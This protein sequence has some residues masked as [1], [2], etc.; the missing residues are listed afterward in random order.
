M[1]LAYSISSHVRFAPFTL[2]VVLPSLRAAGIPPEHIFVCVCGAR[3]ERKVKT[4][5]G[6]LAF[7]Q[8]ESK[9]YAAF[10]EA[11]A[12][13]SIADWWF[14]L[15]DTCKA[16]PRFAKLA[17]QIDESV[18]VMMSSKAHWDPTRIPA[19]LGAYRQSFLEK[20]REYIMGLTD[21]GLE[22]EKGVP[23]YNEG[24]LCSLAHMRG[25]YGTGEC[26][27]DMTPRDVYGA[28]TKRAEWYFPALDLWK[29]QS[30]WG[31]E[32]PRW[33]NQHDTP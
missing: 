11:L 3:R 29:Y 15:M 24:K 17:E 31:K 5:L 13:G 12:W 18:D 20:Q 22:T 26:Q 1:K 2:P 16:G 21:I 7:R 9:V 30:N 19:E 27:K 4:P 14:M 28:G 23:D 6:T 32:K 8:H 25:L 33:K 10:I